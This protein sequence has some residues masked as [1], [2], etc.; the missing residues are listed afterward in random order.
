[1]ILQLPTQD[2]R[3]FLSP[4]PL[5]LRCR[6]LES[7]RLHALMSRLLVACVGGVGPGLRAAAGQGGPPHAPGVVGAA[8][9][10]GG[11]PA[12]P[13]AAHGAQRGRGAAAVRGRSDEVRDG[14]GRGRRGGREGV[15][16]GGPDG[17]TEG[18]AGRPQAAV[19][20]DGLQRDTSRR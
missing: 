15:S 16:A 17:G 9:L 13:D 2:N 14:R 5:E 20:Q 10:H 6:H 3:L 11:S 8:H 12:V 19:A 4:P 1:M 7:W 18:D